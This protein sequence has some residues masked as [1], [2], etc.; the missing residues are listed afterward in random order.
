MRRVALFQERHERLRHQQ[1]AERVRAQCGLEYFRRSRQHVLVVI[2]Q[3]TGV[4]H[5]RIETIA[6]SRKFLRRAPNAVRFGDI[7]L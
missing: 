7:D 1:R 3:N 4:V 5:Q 6:F 2:E